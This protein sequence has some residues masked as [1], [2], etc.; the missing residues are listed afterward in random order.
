MESIEKS[1]GVGGTNLPIDVIKIQNLLNNGAPYAGLDTPL[2]VT[3]LVDAALTDA[4]KRFQAAHPNLKMSNPDGR[5][6]PNGKTLAALNSTAASSS[7]YVN[8]LPS[9]FSSTSLA[10]V[11]SATFV[12][13]FSKQYPSPALSTSTQQSLASL[14]ETIQ[15][16]SPGL[17]VR[18]VAYMLATV[19]HECANTWKPIEEYGKGASRDYGKPVAVTLPDGTTAQN[20]YYGRGYVQLTWATNYQK[21]DKALGPSGT[22][23]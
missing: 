6:D 11:D 18:W 5:V 3:G 9:N 22:S 4:V 23:G 19:K 20:V 21:M 10:N 17:D 8:Y 12:S 2:A 13:L 15:K 14:L 1:V 16:D 7:P